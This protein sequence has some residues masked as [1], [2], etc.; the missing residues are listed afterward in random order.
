MPHPQSPSFDGQRPRRA[1]RRQSQLTIDDDYLA[2]PASEEIFSGPVSESIPTSYT[3]FHHRRR[4][5]SKSRRDPSAEPHNR[6]ETMAYGSITRSPELMTHL[7]TSVGR[8]SLHR[9]NSIV[10]L[11]SVVSGMQLG[12]FNRERSDSRSSFRF[13]SQDEIE[14]AEGASTLPNEIDPVEY[15]VYRRE[16]VDN[17]DYDDDYMPM[18]HQHPNR[19]SYDASFHE[20]SYQRHEEED[21]S[22]AAARRRRRSFDQHLQRW[23][24][25]DDDEPLLSRMNSHLSQE[26][27]FTYPSERLHQRF[28]ISEEDLVIGIAGYRTSRS[29][30]IIYHLL[31]I[32]SLGMA[33]LIL[34]WIP[35]WR[36]ACK[37]IPAPLGQCDW[38]VVE[39]QWGELSVLDVSSLKYNRPMSTVFR[40]LDEEKDENSVQGSSTQEDAESIPTDPDLHTL[41][42]I[43]YRYIKFF[44][45][46]IEDIF[47]TNY[48]WVD[49]NWVDVQEIREGIDNDIQEDRQVVFGPN[50]IDINEKT[51]MQLLVDEVLHPFYI[52]Q[53]FSIILWSFDE[54][55]YYATCIFIISL[56]SVGNTLIETKQTLTR[57]REIARFECDIRVLRS[58]YWTTVRSSDLTPGDIYEV[59]DPSIN[60]FPC[61][62][63]L[64]SGDCIV[65]ESMLT[66]ESVP[67]SKFPATNEA[68][69]RFVSGPGQGS[70]VSPE[71]SRH[72]LYC[73]TKIVQ[74]RRPHSFD[75]PDTQF[76]VAVAMVA[77]TGFTTTKGALVRSMLFP[78]PSGF[79]F[80]QDSFKYIGVMALIAAVGFTI[81]TI[82]F[83]RMH[84]DTSL[85]IFR[86]LDL[87]TIVVP[88]ALPATL[89]IGTNISLA[90]LRDKM[91]FCISP[92]RVNVGGKLDVVCFD[93]TGTLTE[94]GLDVLGI[95]VNEGI[96]NDKKFSELL[97]AMDDVIPSGQIHFGKLAKDANEAIRNAFIAM[98][99]TC[100]S[101]RLVE[102]EL[103]GDPLDV[104][105]FEYTKWKFDEEL[106]SKLF[107]SDYTHSNPV[108]VTYPATGAEPETTLGVVQSFEFVSKLRRMSVMVKS[109]ASQEITVYVKGAPE[110]MPEVCNPSTFPSD[111]DDLL[112]YHTHRG[113]RVI[114]C[115][116]KTLSAS[117]TTKDARALSRQEVE[118]GLE[119][120]G[121]IVFENKLKPSTTAA[122]EELT[123]A[124]IRTVMCTG[125]NA[126]T[127]ISVARE[128]K[129]VTDAA[130]Y[131][132]HFEGDLDA[133]VVL[134]ENIDNRDLKLDPV[135]LD[136]SFY[137]W[138]PTHAFFF[139]LVLTN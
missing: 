19:Y 118:S 20:P 134:W 40:V 7:G 133:S 8:G 2:E 45:N 77:R 60:A 72:F 82:G 132:P 41:R 17:E 74:V 59:S 108:P 66:G 81:S 14:Q 130:I 75:S 97:H 71:I 104:K 69:H 139:P 61:D 78:K 25:Q 58:G 92:N 122:I 37:G 79:K 31:C 136:V 94:D 32:F 95:H 128:C 110:I 34:R 102:G 57:L 43:E 9:T 13:F 11:D 114:A 96:S 98:L 93:K 119:F 64:L 124:G 39:N 65:N 27:D 89:T 47:V 131:V 24:T 90:R 109:L 105:M 50:I 103:V 112:H 53:V 42:T 116:R 16:N 84:M 23:D 6:G 91:I 120:M 33:Y 117:M 107:A 3:S 54:Y 15:E 52:F 129:I 100:H 76:D 87:I 126:L 36:I 68:L 106:G 115:A 67:V 111:Y 28:Y 30:A 29:R 137:L 85:I 46:P 26:F 10:S 48:D 80:Y 12:N 86:A 35:R 121:F 44:Y 56:V 127:A 73:G 21:E 138:I 62:S 125:D 51:T 99:T 4:Y 123:D 55:Y 88:P 135:T 113:Y 49:K 18:P 83:I 22:E 63:I 101:L 5:S 70:T 38:V 1:S